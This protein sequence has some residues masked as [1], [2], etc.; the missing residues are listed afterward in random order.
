MRRVWLPACRFILAH[1]MEARRLASDAPARFE[2]QRT[3]RLAEIDRDR[4]VD[5]AARASRDDRPSVDAAIHVK[6]IA[7][8]WLIGMQSRLT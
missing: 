7:R 5:D 8:I 6:P 2:A 4:V 1:L 3:G